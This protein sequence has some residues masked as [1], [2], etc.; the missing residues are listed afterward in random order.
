MRKKLFIT[1]LAVFSLALVVNAADKPFI[2][3]KDKK[4]ISADSITADSKGT[5]KYKKGKFG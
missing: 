5:L 2:I 4:K 1:V 3:T